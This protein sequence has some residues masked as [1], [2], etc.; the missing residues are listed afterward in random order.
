MNQLY[1]SI[2]VVLFLSLAS[3]SSQAFIFKKECRPLSS[4]ALC[5][6]ATNAS[7]I[8]KTRI[9]PKD[10]P[11]LQKVCSME[12]QYFK[13]VPVGNKCECS[14]DVAST[15]W[16]K[17]PKTRNHE[18][19]ETLFTVI[20]TTQTTDTDL[21]CPILSFPEVRDLAFGLSTSLDIGDR[22]SWQVKKGTWKHKHWASVKGSKKPAGSPNFVKAH[23]ALRH[24]FCTYY[25]PVGLSGSWK[26]E[27]QYRPIK[28]ESFEPKRYRPVT[29]LETTK[30]LGVPSSIPRA[31]AGLKEESAGS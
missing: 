16:F 31:D 28:V 25:V 14:Y 15:Q 27:E 12:E 1:K 4:A 21:E 18:M 10:R 7:P 17:H 9:L 13:G 23:T 24:N 2:G 30:S 20:S 5:R 19:E 6:L 26:N 3:F 29:V 8:A 11:F 22:G